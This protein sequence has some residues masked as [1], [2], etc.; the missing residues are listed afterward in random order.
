[1]YCVTFWSFNKKDVFSFLIS[2]WQKIQAEISAHELTLE[3]LKRNTRSQPPTSPEG[4][5]ARGGNQM[6]VLQVKKES[7]SLL[8]FDVLGVKR[9]TKKQEKKLWG[10]V[11]DFYDFGLRYDV[12]SGMRMMHCL[13]EKEAETNCYMGGKYWIWFYSWIAKREQ[14]RFRTYL[15]IDFSINAEPLSVLVWLVHGE[16][17]GCGIWHHLVLEWWMHDWPWACHEGHFEF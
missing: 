3:E 7:G 4:R 5:N 11:D 6:D 9:Q 13:L 8:L 2:L 15:Y 17:W 14:A 16:G 10:R 12:R 1:M